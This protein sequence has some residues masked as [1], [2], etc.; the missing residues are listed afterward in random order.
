[1]HRLMGCIALLAWVSAATAQSS[2]RPDSLVEDFVE[3][4]VL[5]GW[6]PY[7]VFEHCP[8]MEEW[9]VRAFDLLRAADLD[10]IRQADL[11]MAWAYALRKCDNQDLEVWYYSLV[12]DLA[13]VQGSQAWFPAWT[14]LA[15][16]E[17]PRV[18]ERLFHWAV[19][20]GYPDHFRNAAATAWID[21]GTTDDRLEKYLRAFETGHAPAS[22]ELLASALMAYRPAALIEGVS[23]RIR[24]NPSLAVQGGVLAQFAVGRAPL[25]IRE[26]FADSLLEALDRGEFTTTERRLVQASAEHVRP[27][28]H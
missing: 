16:A 21:S 6:G 11:A 15:G 18:S 14:A 19:D 13:D 27:R 24:L 23:A 1:M 4:G 9:Q 28:R 3:H 17:T 25:A 20:P 22:F 8:R 10:P 5:S 2:V 7:Q 12:V 26:R